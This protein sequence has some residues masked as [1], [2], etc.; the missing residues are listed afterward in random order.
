MAHTHKLV[1]GVRVALTADEIT[2][3]NANDTAWKNDSLNRALEKLRKERTIKLSET[4]YLAL[5]DNT[6]TSQMTTYRQQLRDL[7]SNYT[8]SD[9]SALSEDLS[10][11]VWPT[12]P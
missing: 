5:S 10:N 11:L 4:D 3:L 8:T 9:S 12:K 6:M 2:Q 1:D 7:P